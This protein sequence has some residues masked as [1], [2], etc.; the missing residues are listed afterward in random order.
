MKNERVAQEHWNFTVRVVLWVSI[1]GI[2]RFGFGEVWFR[3]L[4]NSTEWPL[5]EWTMMKN[6]YFSFNFHQ[7]VKLLNNHHR[8]CQKKIVSREGYWK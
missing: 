1:V 3:I 2:V 8:L 4:V 5:Y 6:E 7:K